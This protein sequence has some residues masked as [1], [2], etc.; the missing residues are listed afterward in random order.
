MV[1][2]ETAHLKKQHRFKR[3]LHIYRL[4]VLFSG[5]LLF[6]PEANPARLFFLT[7]SDIPLL[8]TATSLA[9]IVT[10]SAGGWLP[11]NQIISLQWCA[12]VCLFG[13]ILSIFAASFS[14][15]N[16][17]MKKFS[18]FA[19]ILGAAV[20]FI[21]L[22]FLNGKII[23]IKE[24]KPEAVPVFPFGMI[25][26]FIITVTTFVIVVCLSRSMQ[27]VTIEKKMQIEEKYKLFLMLMPVLIITFVFAYLPVYG[28]RLAFFNNGG[29]PDERSYVGVQWFSYMFEN[30]SSLFELLRVL[31]NTLIMSVLTLLSSVLPLLLAAFIHEIRAKKL[32]Y[33]LQASS[34]IPGFL[35]WPVIFS[36]AFVFFSSDGF[37]NHF[38][39]N[40][41]SFFSETDY[42]RISDGI[43]IQMLLW[44]LWKGVGI[45]SIIYLVGLS[46]VDHTLYES[47][48]VEGAS[49]WQKIR[50]ISLPAMKQLF[51]IVLLI[52]FSDLLT[53]DLQQYLLFSNEVNASLLNVL[54]LYVY[55]IGVDQNII[56]HST[57]ISICKSVFGLILYFIINRIS[58]SVRNERIF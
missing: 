27:N 13:I 32:C 50:H 16:N 8:T 17:R 36:I 42:L 48:F 4:L 1:M 34:I 18:F 5:I 30:N 9:S 58:L 44:Q 6:I 28:W 23:E 37:F 7:S 33:V 55:D 47:A 15:G 57:A 49:H 26:W 45:N 3:C 11:G 39:L 51:F 12:V 14:L 10:A 20:L 38:L 40:I 19:G 56:P 2:Q 43:W 35:S 25:I 46:S 53:N 31:R 52:S 21:G 29:T 22:C 24:M 54:D 41:F